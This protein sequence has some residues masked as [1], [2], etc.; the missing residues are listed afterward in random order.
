MTNVIGKLQLEVFVLT[1]RDPLH[2]T[3]TIPGYAVRLRNDRE[4]EVEVAKEQGL[5]DVFARLSAQGLHVSSMRTK[6]NRLEELFIRLVDRKE[7]KSA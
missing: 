2:A 3:P 1:L 5:N 6:S 4:I 7:R